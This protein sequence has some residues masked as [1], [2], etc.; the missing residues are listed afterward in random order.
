MKNR[1]STKNDSFVCGELHFLC[2]YTAEEVGT[3]HFGTGEKPNH[4]PF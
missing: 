3:E 1:I 4:S 2:T